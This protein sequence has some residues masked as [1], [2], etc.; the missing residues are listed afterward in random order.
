MR[1]RTAVAWIAAAGTRW[2]L[3]VANTRGAWPRCASDQ[4]MRPE[5]KMPLLHEDVAAV[6]TTTL[7]MAAAAGTP[8]FSNT[9]TN[10]LT[11]GLSSFHGTSDMMMSTAPM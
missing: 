4:S 6:M 11:L 10:G 1:S 7:M 3:R 5:L 9:N 8:I 2:L